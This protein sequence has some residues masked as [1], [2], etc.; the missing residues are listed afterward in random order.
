MMATSPGYLDDIV[1]VALHVQLSEGRDLPRRRHGPSDDGSDKLF[2]LAVGRKEA[3]TAG[4]LGCRPWHHGGS[5]NIM[6]SSSNFENYNYL[7]AIYYIAV[8]RYVL[9][10]L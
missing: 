9:L 3:P 5:Y 10:Y 4:K 6:L 2:S 1:G 7:V 8:L